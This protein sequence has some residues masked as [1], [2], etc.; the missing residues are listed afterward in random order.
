VSEFTTV[1]AE[2]HANVL[3]VT[4]G[5]ET[6]E[7]LLWALGPTL[8]HLRA[9]GLG[10]QL[11]R[12]NVL[13]L[14]ITDEVDN[15]HVGGDILLLGDDMHTEII[16]T[17]STL[18]GGEIEVI[19]ES[20][21]VGTKTD[22]ERIEVLDLGGVDEGS[23]G[24]SSVHLRHTSPV[25]HTTLVA[26]ES[27]VARLIAEPALHRVR[28]A[29]TGG[30]TLFAAGVAGSAEGTLN[31]LIGAVCLVVTDLAAV[32]ALASETAALGLVGAL[33]GEVASLAASVL[34]VSMWK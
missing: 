25:N 4:T 20:T 27:L 8:C 28:R 24:I 5:S 26:V 21:S 31:T 34:E 9:T 19:L 12:K 15:G 10:R 22:A 30:V 3:D 23:P 1:G 18:D 14:S 2:R 17:Q 32:E 6:L 7:V 33:P 29:S 16:V 13:A 11:D